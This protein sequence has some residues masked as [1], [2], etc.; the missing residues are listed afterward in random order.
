LKRRNFLPA[1]VAETGK[2]LWTFRSDDSWRALPMTYMLDGRQYIAGMDGT[3]VISF[4]LG[5]K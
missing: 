3:N 5:Y 2:T 1:A 4:A